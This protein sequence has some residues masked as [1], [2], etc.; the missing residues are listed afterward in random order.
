M[1]LD[2]PNRATKR[3]NFRL[4]CLRVYEFEE[5]YPASGVSFLE[6]D[7]YSPGDESP[8]YC[9]EDSEEPIQTKPCRDPPALN[10]ASLLVSSSG[11]TG[12]QKKNKRGKKVRR[13]PTSVSVSAMSE[14]LSSNQQPIQEKVCDSD[15]MYATQAEENEEEPPPSI[16]LSNL[17][18]DPRGSFIVTAD[19]I[20]SV[21]LILVSSNNL[22]VVPFVASGIPSDRAWH[23]SGLLEQ[24]IQQRILT[25]NEDEVYRSFLKVCDQVCKLEEVWTEIVNGVPD[26]PSDDGQINLLENTFK[27][28]GISAGSPTDDFQL[29]SSWLWLKEHTPA[30]ASPDADTS[31]TCLICFDRPLEHSGL[32]C[33]ATCGHCVCAGCWAAYIQSTAKSGQPA[34]ISCPGHKCKAS[35]DL[36]DAAHVLFNVSSSL[37]ETTTIFN[38]MVSNE[39]EHYCRQAKIGRFCRSPT[40]GRLLTPS[41][42]GTD[43]EAGSGWNILQCSCGATLCADCPGSER[44]HPGVSCSRYIEFRENIDSGKADSEYASYLYLLQHSRPCPR[45]HFPIERDG[46]CNHVRCTK[47]RYY[48]CWMCGGLGNECMAYFCSKTQKRFEDEA[49]KPDDDAHI[50]SIVAEMNK[51]RS[52]RQ[53]ENRLLKIEK[54]LQS[55]G[56]IAMNER[57]ALLTFERPL[58]QVLVWIYAAQLLDDLAVKPVCAQLQQLELIAHA[59]EVRS[60]IK[61]SLVGPFSQKQVAQAIGL[62]N[63]SK[64]KRLSK[65]KKQA[66]AQRKQQLQTGDRDLHAILADQDLQ[67]LCT[68]DRANFCTATN[69]AIKEA[70]QLLWKNPKQQRQNRK[71]PALPAE[72]HLNKKMERARDPWK[73]GMRVAEGTAASRTGDHKKCRWKGK[74]RAKILRENAL[75]RAES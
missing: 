50:N 48:F 44:A 12:N 55:F 32:S 52:Y 10:L 46:G 30:K 27:Q 21:F 24:A 34:S 51:Y 40:C 36:F 61:G 72:G 70:I 68:M 33:L 31:E 65:R 60:R 66:M 6:A 29:L 41:T 22:K 43:F 69:K 53:A 23:I 62:G 37:C 26:T 3:R 20:R 13:N 14:H 15:A 11:T 7:E 39:L 74:F 73:I 64:K 2:P 71:K 45:C 18:P 1:V 56:S 42:R 54:A 25:P 35:I 19:R 75:T 67:D 16:Y 59:F 28:S 47:C 17:G 38:K 49:P 9:F 4:D 58:L 63:A 8:S 5:I 57:I